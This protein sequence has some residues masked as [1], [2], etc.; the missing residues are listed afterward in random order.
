MFILFPQ[1][2]SVALGVHRFKRIDGHASHYA[3]NSQNVGRQ[4]RQE[5]GE[6]RV[7]RAEDIRVIPEVEVGKRDADDM[8]YADE[9]EQKVNERQVNE[10]PERR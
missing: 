4:M 10:K 7:Q 5:D 9:Y 6:E 3:D 2:E 1:V 8:R